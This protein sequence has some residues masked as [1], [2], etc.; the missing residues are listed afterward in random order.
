MELDGGVG[1]RVARRVPE[2]ATERDVPRLI[3]I[4][5]MGAFLERRG[6]RLVD[7]VE[8]RRPALPQLQYLLL[9]LCHVYVY[10]QSRCGVAWST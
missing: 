1:W 6:D 3:I 9:H 5:T 7:G 8:A 10:E 2:A 4:V